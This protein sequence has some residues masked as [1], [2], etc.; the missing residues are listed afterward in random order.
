[1]FATSPSD[2]SAANVHSFNDGLDF[3]NALSP[4]PDD[5]GQCFDPI[6]PI[7]DS[8]PDPD[9]SAAAIAEPEKAINL[10]TSNVVVMAN[11]RCHLV[12]KDIARRG[13]DV[14]Y[15]AAKNHVIMRLRRPYIVATIWS[16]GKIWCTG[17]SS[18]SKAKKGARRIA[19]RLVKMGYACRFSNYRIL[20]VMAKCRLPFRVRLDSLSKTRPRQMSYEPELTPGLT[21]KIPE[22]P[23]LSLTLFSTGRL[24]I[25]GSSLEDITN[26]VEELVSLACLH[27]SDEAPS[28][29]SDDECASACSGDKNSQ[30]RQY[31]R[32][33]RGRSRR[34]SAFTEMAAQEIPELADVFFEELEAEELEEQEALSVVGLSEEGNKRAG[35]EEKTGVSQNVAAVAPEPTPPTPRDLDNVRSGP[36]KLPRIITYD[37]QLQQESSCV[38]TTPQAT[39]FIYATTPGSNQVVRYIAAPGSQIANSTFTQQQPQQTK[40]VCGVQPQP[41][42]N[43][44]RIVSPMQVTN[45]SQQPQR[46][47]I[48]RLPAGTTILNPNTTF[49]MTSGNQLILNGQPTQIFRTIAPSNT[50]TVNTNPST[51]T[52]VNNPD[53]SPNSGSQTSC[54][55][56]MET[57]FA[58]MKLEK[59]MDN[60]TFYGYV[61]AVSGPVVIAA[62][63][64]GSAMYELVRVGHDNLV[65]EIIRLEGDTATIQVY[66]DTSGVT[67]GDPVLKTGKPLS[68]ELGPGI[69]GSIFDGIQRP[70]QAIRD[71]T[72][73]I[74][75]PKGIDAPCLDRKKAWEFTPNPAIRPGMHITGGDIY[76]S[77]VEN[78]LIEH[79]LML[80]PKAM[81]T[82]KWI[83]PAGSYTILDKVLE[84]DYEGNITEH[85]MLQIWP[86]RQP[87]P[88]ADKLPANFP[89]FTGQRVLDTLFP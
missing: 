71:F 27:Q 85:S 55:Q 33:R 87:R 84:T 58:N 39:Q 32:R 38:S 48:N 81:G 22:T 74:Y 61:H 14:E 8:K 60:E 3:L 73:S 88:V 46:F 69:L 18:I 17:A 43:V 49:L 82:V 51:S 89:L 13:I 68:V 4:I 12:L 59:Q 16:S 76:G 80:P 77:V 2:P 75:I 67:V 52:S 9:P 25:M 1:M 40:I 15:K 83:A 78:S 36:K 28:D 35:S 42:T 10:S 26:A 63:M 70:L 45:Q 56:L 20:N 64:S 50:V 79:R 62:Q 54:R 47:I 11:M 57:A 41:T 31:Y 7:T 21:F 53:L 37:Q 23:S 24:V 30:R 29:S 65:G 5:Q 72:Q 44:V 6:P 86:V 19:R 66:E 34:M